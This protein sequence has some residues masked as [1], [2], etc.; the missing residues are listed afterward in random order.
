MHIL[1]ILCTFAAD[2]YRIMST[3][4][5]ISKQIETSKK[6]IN[7]FERKITMYQERR[8]K[9][10]AAANKKYGIAIKAEDIVKEK[11]GNERYQWYEYVMPEWIKGT[12]DFETAN[13][14]TGACDYMEENAKNKRI[15][16]ANLERLQK[17][18]ESL[19][20]KAKAEAER[21]NNGLDVA[22]RKSLNGFRIVWT[23]RMI[24]WHSNHYDYIKNNT[25]SAITRRN[26]IRGLQQ[27]FDRYHLRNV[28]GKIIANLNMAVYVCNEII[29]DVVNRYASK[30]DYIAYIGERLEKTW[31]KGI[32]KLTKKCQ[33]FGVDENNVSTCSP[34]MTDKGFEVVIKDGKPRVIK[35]RIIWAAEYSNIVEPHTRYIVTEK[36]IK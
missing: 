20:A 36:R 24:E 9:N 34:E 29:M 8:D 28:H 26:R 11:R 19:E 7:D 32:V 1:N 17:E 5:Q 22:L 18:L 30:L 10:I 27:Y 25:A 2:K 4:K 35:A 33:D 14:I 31:D 23:K 16:L 13:K 3:I 12:V 15:E 21:Y 6:R